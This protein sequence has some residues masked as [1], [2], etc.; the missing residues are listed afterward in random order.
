[1]KQLLLMLLTALVILLAGC[2]APGPNDMAPPMPAAP[3]AAP[4]M[5]TPAD[6]DWDSGVVTGGGGVFLNRESAWAEAEQSLQLKEANEADGI[7]L[8]FEENAF[9]SPKEHPLLTFSLKVDTAAYTNTARYLEG[10]QLPP[11]SAVRTEEMI[12]YFSYEEELEFPEGSPFALSTQLGSSPFDPE[13]QLAFLRVKTRD[14][15]K[16][17]LPGSHLIFLI[18][19]S[20]S[21]S[22]YNKLPLL[23]QSFSLLTQCLDESDRVS[24]IS[25]GGTAQVLLENVSGEDTRSITKAVNSLTAG[26]STGGEEGLRTAYRLAEEYWMEGGNNRIILATDGG[27]NV[28]ASQV[29]EIIALLEEENRP[30]LALSILGFGSDVLRDDL[31]ETLSKHGNG[32]YSYINSLPTAQK[33]LVEELGTNLYTAAWNVKAQVDFDPE[34]IA[35]YRLIG[36]E[37]RWMEASAFADDS[38]DAGEIGIRADMV[39]LLELELQPEVTPPDELFT[40]QIRYKNPGQSESN[41]VEYPVTGEQITPHPGS[42][43][44]FASSVA[45]FGHLLRGSE[46]TGEA[47]LAQAIQLAEGSLGE[48]PGGYRQDYLGLLNRYGEILASLDSP[49]Q[50]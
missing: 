9:Y 36:Y 8:P 40:L 19:T 17:D 41:L 31:L 6:E 24:I 33:V 22:A 3:Q 29:E 28:G 39:I 4:P 7:Y 44:Q 50:G 27:F 32:N 15:E 38:K 13:K 34:A 35:S 21:M 5:D 11:W 25:Y 42:D 20:G 18:D 16:K 12:N 1:M 48:D 49:P 45:V 47:T 23:K 43:F 37:N 46:H 14:V 10:G 2:S 26:G 30:D